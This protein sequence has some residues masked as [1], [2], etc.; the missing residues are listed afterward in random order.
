MQWVWHVCGTYQLHTCTLIAHTSDM[1]AT[2]VLHFRI[3]HSSVVQ[4]QKES[5]IKAVLRVPHE[6]TVNAVCTRAAL[7]VCTRTA[8]MYCLCVWYACHT[9]VTRMH[10]V[11]DAFVSHLCFQIQHT[12]C[13]YVACM[14]HVCCLFYARLILY[15]LHAWYGCH[16][17]I[18]T[19]ETQNH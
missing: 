19:M 18:V 1:Y 14:Q 4:V 5:N 13:M 10:D 11:C 12:C 6:C 16:S 15:V 7:I 9:H 2:R 3:S 17:L 8:P